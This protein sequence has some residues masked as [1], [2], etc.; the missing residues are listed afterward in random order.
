MAKQA[1]LF[2]PPEV[3]EAVLANEARN[4]AEKDRQGALILDLLSQVDRL[5]DERDALLRWIHG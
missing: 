4:R 3:I 5:T 2:P 1:S